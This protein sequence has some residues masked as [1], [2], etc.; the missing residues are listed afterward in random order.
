MRKLNLLIAAAIVCLGTASVLAQSGTGRISGTVKD[1]SG[2]LVPGAAVIAQHEQTGVRHTTTTTQSGLFVFPSL[3]IGSYSVTAELQGFKRAT[4][5]KNLLTVASDLNVPITMDPGGL[6][7]TVTV[8]S[9]AKLVQSTESS[10]STLVNEQT[11]VTLPLNGRNPLHLLGLVPG[12][13]GHS[14][15][16]T[17]SGGT[18]THNVNGD[19]GRGITSTVDGVDISDPVIPRG[20]L[21]NAP[22]NP[23]AIEEFRIITSNPKAE[24][25]RT[26]GAQ[27]E[28]VT[29]SGTNKLKGSVY[30][31]MRNTSFDTNSYF[32]KLRG[33]PTEELSRHQFGVTLGGP[34]KRDKAFF[35]VNYEGQRR[36]QDTSQVVTVPTQAL[37][38]GTYRFVTSACAGGTTV[39]NRPG[40][41]DPSGNALVPVSSYNYVANDPRRLGL[42]PVM[43][44]E[45]LKFLPLPND[46]TTG[47]GL[48]FAGYRWNSP[49]E[50]PVD[51]VTS[52][53]DYTFSPKHS[54]FLRYSQALRNDL[55]NDIINTNPRPMSWPARVRLSDQ[56]AAAL[57]LKSSLRSH[58]FNELTIGFTRNVLEFAD[59]EHP[60]TYEIRNPTVSVPF[61]YWS[62]TG[63]KPLEINL[64]D[65]ISYI[66][67][68]HAF[69]LGAQVRAYYIDQQ[70]G[71]GNPFGIYP[72]F[73]FGRLDAPF[74][75]ADTGA[76]RR[77][78]GSFANLTG[79]GINATDSNNLQT[80]Y[81]MMLGRVGRI[82]QVFYSD[83][84]KY[85][86]LQ[87][88]TLKQRLKEYNFY[89]QDDWR[90]TPKLTL[91]AGVR[92][93]LNT[94]PYDESGVQVVADRPL[95]GSQGP[96]TFLQGGP[97]TGLSWFNM[98]KN[99][100]APVVG[101]AY[102]VKGDGKFKV[103]GSYRIAYQR[104]VSWALNVVEQRQ[105]ATS[106]NQFILGPRSA[107][108]GG[109]DSIIRL[110]EM[111]KGGRLPDPQGGVSVVPANGVPYLNAPATIQRTPP[112]NRGERPLSF[113][114]DM[115]TPYVQQWTAG[116]QKQLGSRM[117]VEANYV[118]SKG[119]NLFR[120]VNVNQMD[121]NANGFVRDFQAAQRNLAA[122]GNPN[123]GESTGNYGRLYGGT[124]PTA[125]YGDIRN[126][127]VGFVAD[128]LDRGTIGITLARAGLPDN[129]FRRNPQFAVA[130]QG[131]S[132]SSSWYNGL[133]MQLRGRIGSSL[134]FAAN[135]TFSK[136]IDD[137]SHDTN[138]A[139][140]NIIVPSDAKNPMADKARSDHDVTHVAR[141]FV[142]WDVPVGKDRR[143]L[144]NAGKLTDW[145]L[146]G[147]QINGILDASSGYPFSVFSGF[148]TFTFYDDGTNVA[149]TG[150]A[151]NRA[152]Y[153]GSSKNIGRITETGTGVQFLSPEERALFSAPQPGEVGSGRNMF[154]GPG[155]FQFD[156]GLFKNFRIDD[157]RRV[158]LRMEVFNVFDSVNFSQPNATLTAG[159]FGTINGTRVP[160]RTIQLGAKLY[161]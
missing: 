113:P 43:Q 134:N 71:A 138:G 47:D 11:I 72:A 120:M 5:T 18:A 86:P 38:D 33:L 150:G 26:A 131:C 65:N 143:F 75:G 21:A 82:D 35:F 39:A 156:L 118:G 7:E 24:Y 93:E 73:T 91:N 106:L 140:T 126:G 110:N 15:E 89:V 154:T 17:A 103:S 2:A 1:T 56:Q 68:N 36:T 116:V 76:V 81:N 16:A 117:M 129:F 25:G 108:I 41:V 153:N 14:G 148:H 105:P 92:Y 66:R 4:R 61:V 133:Q 107:A 49:S 23:D 161:F 22:V 109:T 112:N 139:G 53:F 60:K 123:V 31:F 151:T 6:E 70:R 142:I 40:C 8:T 96:V 125:A 19:R 114:Q 10:L 100:I 37:R 146:G 144:S 88:L 102:D 104:L 46:F 32:N 135:Y 136:S 98:D 54:A 128:A 152:V 160:P 137:L 111:L 159:A 99:N 67:G 95:D 44:N 50:Q 78:D 64:A 9:E 12:V 48:N 28:M 30:E 3:P 122:T 119:M 29:K 101:L 84:Q 141:G 69:K 158:E 52:R 147:W 132:C 59:P 57:G 79:S 149:S 74:S 58:V 27:I 20:E 97:G 155:F 42:D 80:L 85:V 115:V 45:S 77:P 55:I 121:L 34:I 124:I 130:G 157:S 90:I 87:P 83:G 145:L 51:T 127:N 94:V 13:V 63:R 62:G